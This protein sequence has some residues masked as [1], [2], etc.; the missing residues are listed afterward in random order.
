V[1]DNQSSFLF[2]I[3][4]NLA[5]DYQRSERRRLLSPYDVESILAVPDDTPGPEASAI[6]RDELA[7]LQEALAELPQRRRE[8]F[9]MSR[10]DGIKQRTIAEK[11]GINIRTV[12]NEILRALTHCAVRLRK[13]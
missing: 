9:L 4:A 10:L 13:K 7:I 8:I 2:R 11:Y 5:T 12:E 3:A 6:A 1:V